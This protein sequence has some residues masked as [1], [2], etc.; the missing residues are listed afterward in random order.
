M[1]KIYWLQ[2]VGQCGSN[3]DIRISIPAGLTLDQTAKIE[4]RVH[5]TVGIYGI[6]NNGDYERF[7]YNEAV[8]KVLD[9]MD[10]IYEYAPAEYTIYL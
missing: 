6:E 10:V 8:E 5:D 3:L 4:Q 9:E 7:N 2:I 1:K